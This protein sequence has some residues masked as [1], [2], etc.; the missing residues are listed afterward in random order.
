MSF[1]GTYLPTY[2]VVAQSLNLFIAQSVT[3]SVP[4][5]SKIISASELYK[6][7]KARGGKINF[8]GGGKIF[9]GYEQCE[10]I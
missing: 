4:F 9:A 1:V 7:Q 3:N 5:L 2:L 6:G 10:L 8:Y